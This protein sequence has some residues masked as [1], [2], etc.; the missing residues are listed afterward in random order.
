MSSSSQGT[1]SGMANGRDDSQHP[2][3][4][5]GSQPRDAETTHY[6][7]TTCGQPMVGG[8]S[9]ASGHSID[10]NSALFN[11]PY[12][13]LGL[14]P[15]LPRNT[16]GLEGSGY[17]TIESLQARLP[18]LPLRPESAPGPTGT[19]Q[20]DF[21]TTQLARLFASHGGS[22]NSSHGQQ[23]Q[24]GA[25]VSDNEI[26]RREKEL[27]RQRQIQGLDPGVQAQAQARARAQAQAQA[28]AQVEAQSQVEAQA[29]AQAQ[30]AQQGVGGGSGFMQTASISPLSSP[31]RRFLAASQTPSGAGLALPLGPF[32][33]PQADPR[34]SADGF[35]QFGAPRSL[36]SVSNNN[37]NTII[38]SA[39][40]KRPSTDG[41]PAGDGRPT[42]RPRGRP[43]KQPSTDGVPATKRPRGRPR[44]QPRDSAILKQ[45]DTNDDAM[46]EIQSQP[47]PL[48]QEAP[49]IHSGLL[50]PAPAP[51]SQ[52]PL[53]QEYD[54][55]ALEDAVRRENEHEAAVAAAERQAQQQQQPEEENRRIPPM[56]WPA[57][58]AWPGDRSHYPSEILTPQMVARATASMAREGGVYLAVY[59]AEAVHVGWS[60]MTARR[61][62]D[63]ANNDAASSTSPSSSESFSSLFG[64]YTSEKTSEKTPDSPGRMVA[65]SVYALSAP[66]GSGI[67]LRRMRKD[68]ASAEEIRAGG[69][70]V[71]WGDVNSGNA[72]FGGME[73]ALAETW[74]DKLLTLVPGQGDA[75]V[76]WR[77][78]GRDG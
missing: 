56:A 55:S 17:E 48:T 38:D 35:S 51:I 47:L 18:E 30:P 7:L 21:L 63:N 46:Q 59:L 76:K 29:Q 73:T 32:P 25:H 64:S 40:K 60:F 15:L 8:S 4:A 54:L 75:L 12:A 52:G 31:H 41:V 69:E 6:D 39:S 42:K 49:P 9:T 74:V 58:M 43:R 16:R 10:G 14:A 78:M 62:S 72:Y 61:R 45:T 1:P 2:D 71:G 66:D 26:I 27:Y 67:E 20:P 3:P 44:K 23:Q 57:H 70:P 34:P 19:S 53:Q 50:F 13:G 33:E 28:Q 77:R 65:C 37:N 36:P 5:T 24:P 11:A 22:S 68:G